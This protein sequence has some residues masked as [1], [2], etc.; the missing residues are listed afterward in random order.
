[1]NARL[2]WGKRGGGVCLGCLLNFC[3]ILVFS[4]SRSFIFFMCKKMMT[5]K[6]YIALWLIRSTLAVFCFLVTDKLLSQPGMPFKYLESM[7]VM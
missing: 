4:L 3:K 5:S 1:M 2:G 6:M 7:G